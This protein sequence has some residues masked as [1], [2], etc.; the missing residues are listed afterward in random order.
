MCQPATASSLNCLVDDTADPV[1]EHVPK[2]SLKT[3][4]HW[5]SINVRPG[6]RESDVKYHKTE[7]PK[8]TDAL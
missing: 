2:P 6:R 5:D 7:L 3:L 8:F 4:L 1:S